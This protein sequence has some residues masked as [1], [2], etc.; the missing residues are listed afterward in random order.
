MKKLLLSISII[1]FIASCVGAKKNIEKELNS[2]NYDRAISNALNKLKNNKEKKRKADYIYLLKNAFSK[3]V[4]RDKETIDFLKKEANPANY[5]KIYEM[6]VA[7][8]SRQELI[9]PVL[10]LHINGKK[11]NFSFSNYNDEIIDYKLKTSNYLYNNAKKLLISTHKPNYR[12]AYSDLEYLQKI[13][14]DYKDVKQLMEKAHFK[15]TD[16]VT[17]S[18]KNQTQQVIP[19]RLENELL[20]FNTYGLND[21]WTIYHSAKDQSVNYD[22]AMSLNFRTINVSP[23]QIKEREIIREKQVVDGWKYALDTEGNVLKDS[24]GNKIKVDKY[25]TVICEYYESQ[26]LKTS[27]IKGNVVFSDLKTNQNIDTFPIESEFIF[28]HIYATSRGDRRAL[29]QELLSFLNNR[30]VNFPSNEQMI[31]DTGEDLKNRLKEI[32]TRQRFN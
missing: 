27:Y 26:Q 1:T 16:F 24:L 17:V 5:E 21:F 7:L 14:P 30:R 11:T 19:K 31:Y 6:Y 15:G 10:P 13:N 23:E 32:I 28:E 20:N 25:A 4:I 12:K 29:E 9:K 2:G 8:N 18:M 3:A 22:Y